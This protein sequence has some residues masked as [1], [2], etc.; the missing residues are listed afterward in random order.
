MFNLNEAYTPI[1]TEEILSKVPQ[2]ILWK[3][4]C[5]QWEVGKSFLSPLYKDTRPSCSIFSTTDNNLMLKDF[6]TGQT[7]NIF[8]FVGTKYGIN[9]K[10]TLDVIANDFGLRK[11][12][13][14]VTPKEYK[15]LSIEEGLLLKPSKTTITIEKQAYNYT[16][17]DYWTNTFKIPLTI[18]ESYNVH[19]CKSVYLYKT[20][21]VIR[22]DY[23]KNSPIYAYEF[24]HDGNISYK[25]YFPLH[26]EKRFR[27][28][29][30]GTK[31]N[32][33]GFDQLDWHGDILI[34]TKSL[35]DCMA[36]RVFGYNA[37]S[38]QGETNTLTQSLVD[39]LLSR[40]NRIIV[41]YDND[42]EGIKNTNKIVERYKFKFFYIDEAKDLSD[43]IRDFGIL[44]A[45]EML[46]LKINNEIT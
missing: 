2:H 43:Y 22:F 46:N 9:F 16:D 29:F 27:F 34:L 32:I 5:P 44:K 15:N 18:L 11:I 35:K 10:E 21:K 33:E 26:P 17:Y 7:Y 37:I 14:S 4:Y 41:N 38:L 42:E 23:K 31:D 1:T 40:Y 12:Q 3:Y 30:G 45:K 8:S 24:V 13:Y 36:Y 39:K 28:L 6:G 19:S 20:D 25:I